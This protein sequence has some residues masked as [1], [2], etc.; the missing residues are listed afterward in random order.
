MDRSW[1]LGQ[2]GLRREIPRVLGTGLVVVVI[3]AFSLAAIASLGV[4][5]A[6]L[7]SIGVA[8]GSVTSLAILVLYFHPWLVVGIGIDVALLWSVVVAG[9]IPNGLGR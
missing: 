8:I 2:V 9:W 1:L 3:A 7:W 4:G 5:P 6:W